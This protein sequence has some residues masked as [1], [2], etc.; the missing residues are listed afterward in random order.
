MSRVFIDPDLV[1]FRAKQR[2][3]SYQTYSVGGRDHA[4]LRNAHSTISYAYDP[5]HHGDGTLSWRIS[6]SDDVP[7]L[8]A[9]AAPLTLEEIMAAA[10]PLVWSVFPRIVGGSRVCFSSVEHCDVVRQV[11][12][13]VRVSVRPA[14]GSHCPAD[15]VTSF[16][17]Q[18]PEQVNRLLPV[19]HALTAQLA[20][21]N[22]A[23]R[24]ALKG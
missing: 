15:V 9:P 21:L 1:A 10:D 16:H 7:D 2:G 19:V 17:T 22:Y 18:D 11:V 3:L 5:E 8:Y 24:Q 12:P 6:K 4:V 23:Y 20:E 14:D 13:A